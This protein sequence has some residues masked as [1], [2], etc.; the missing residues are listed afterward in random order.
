MP[1]DITNVARPKGITRLIR[2]CL[3]AAMGTNRLLSQ[4][5]LDAIKKAR[6][7][8]VVVSKAK[9]HH[10]SCKA[11]RHH[12][13][14]QGL[15]CSNGHEWVTFAMQSRCNKEGTS[16]ESGRLLSKAISLTRGVRSPGTPRGLRK[17]HSPPPR[18]DY[19]SSG[20]PKPPPGLR[21]GMP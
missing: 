6:V 11:L 17:S 8:R 2:G 5:N 10:Q 16:G 19:L 3:T 7:G 9:I 14:Y 13:T 21:R 12:Q 15:F 1:K 4:C 18:Q 20:T